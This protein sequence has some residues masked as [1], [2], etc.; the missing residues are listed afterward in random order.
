MSRYQQSISAS[1]TL[2]INKIPIFNW[3]NAN[4]NYQGTY[5]WTASAQ[6]IQDRLGNTIENTNNISANANLDFTK[7]YNKVPYLKQLGSTKRNNNN[8]GKNGG[9][10]DKKK[11]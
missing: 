2:P 3:I 7:L 10:Q 4:A 11:E 6:S 9:K 5:F 1:Y 8:N